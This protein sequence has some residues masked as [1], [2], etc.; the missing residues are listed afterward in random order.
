MTGPGNP[1]RTLRTAVPNGHPQEARPTHPPPSP[2]PRPPRAYLDVPDSTFAHYWD[3]TAPTPSQL[4]QADT[5]FTTHAP[6]LVWSSPKFRVIPA[7]EMP[8]VAFLGR[9]NVGKSSVLNAVLGRHICHTSRKPGR[10]KTMNAFDVGSNRLTVLD[11]PGYGAGSRPE[12]GEEIVKYLRERKQLR[13]AFLLISTLHGVKRTDAEL[14]ALF[15][16]HGVPH[17]IILSKVDELLAPHATRPPS[18]EAFERNL[19]K[20]RVV[21]DTLREAVQPRDQRG[22]SA[23]G[24]IVSCSAVRGLEAG[25]GKMGVAAVRWAVLK[26]VGS[27]VGAGASVGGGGW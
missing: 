13:R 12:W 26:A 8:E 11:M 17:Q 6:K 21:F 5:F 16:A 14:L 2:P 1:A 24:E 7:S 15:R 3:T 20:L 9:S 25:K 4:A 18:Q 19:A 27:R 23:L 22:P 10:T